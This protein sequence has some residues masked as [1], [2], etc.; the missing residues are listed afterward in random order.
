MSIKRTFLVL[1]VALLLAL[2]LQLL[3]YGTYVTYETISNVTFVLGIVIFFSSLIA[4]TGAYEVMYG[5]RY[6][7]RTL[8]DWNYRK[9]VKSIQEYREKKT[10]KKET[11]SSIYKEI[12]L[13][14]F[15]FLIVAI[16]TGGKM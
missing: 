10:L 12:L 13:V 14:S 3:L 7:L 11:D 1:G 5:I 4:V 8:Y 6:S 2:G 16:F 9:E 15:L